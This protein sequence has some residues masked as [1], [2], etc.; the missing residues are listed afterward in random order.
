MG[1]TDQT[2]VVSQSGVP[3]LLFLA[4]R[5]PLQLH[6]EVF[7]TEKTQNQQN[8]NHDPE[9]DREPVDRLLIIC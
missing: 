5:L 3:L 8:Q 6:P 2:P 7:I 1:L 4:D 9:P